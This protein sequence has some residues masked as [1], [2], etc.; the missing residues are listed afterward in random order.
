MWV[1]WPAHG[2]ALHFRVMRDPVWTTWIGGGGASAVF[3][4]R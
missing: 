1:E 3:A 2:Q 4:R